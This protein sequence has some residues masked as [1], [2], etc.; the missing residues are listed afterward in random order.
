MN[1]RGQIPIIFQKKNSRG[2]F[3]LVATI[4]IIGLVISLSVMTNYST[5]TDSYSIEKVAKE[6]SI[7]GQKVLDYDFANSANEFGDFSMKYSA[8]AGE[9]KD[10]YFIVVDESNGIEEAYKYT[11]GEKVD[12]HGDLVVGQ[13]I[14]FTLDNKEYNFK[15]EDGE[16]FYFVLIYDKGGER[17]VYTG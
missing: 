3:Y 17:Y 9:D 8:Y 15:L 6:L 5:K 2:Q 11:N 13:G 1:K 14:K 10:I 16:N 12:L 7:E 4:I